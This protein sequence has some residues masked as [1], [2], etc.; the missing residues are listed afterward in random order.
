MIQKQAYILTIMFLSNLIN[1]VG[2]KKNSNRFIV[3]HAETMKTDLNFQ[4][5]PELS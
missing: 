5:K 3:K 2:R 4:I 1:M